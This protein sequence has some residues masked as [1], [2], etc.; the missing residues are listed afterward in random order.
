MGIG[1]ARLFGLPRKTKNRQALVNCCDGQTNEHIM[2]YVGSQEHSIMHHKDYPWIQLES[3][4]ANCQI[5]EEYDQ[6]PLN[7]DSGNQWL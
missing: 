2:G 1:S 3:E 6:G 7:L 5:N 4:A